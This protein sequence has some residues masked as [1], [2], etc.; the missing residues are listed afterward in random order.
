[1]KEVAIESVFFSLVFIYEIIAFAI[2][3]THTERQEKKVKKSLLKIDELNS[4]YIV[5]IVKHIYVFP[6]YTVT[7]FSS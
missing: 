2:A 4:I 3:F 7:F 1:M 6:I 5:G